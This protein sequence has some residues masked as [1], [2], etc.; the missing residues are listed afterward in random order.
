MLQGALDRSN[1]N[2]TPRQREM[3]LDYCCCMFD[4][5]T[6]MA[7]IP[8]QNTI[9]SALARSIQT[10]PMFAYLGSGR[11]GNFAVV[12]KPILGKDT[13]NPNNYK[14]ALVNATE[15]IPG[16]TNWAAEGTYVQV[17]GG[18][19]IRMDKYINE[20]T[21]GSPGFFGVNIGGTATTT[22]P[23]GASPVLDPLNTGN[24]VHWEVD[25]SGDSPTISAG[26]GVYM[27]TIY[28]AQ[29]TPTFTFVPDSSILFETAEKDD[30]G[31]PTGTTYWINSSTDWSLRIGADA[32]NTNSWMTV[33]PGA[34]NG[35]PPWLNG[36]A[37][38]MIRPV[39]MTML[40]TP[41][42]SAL[43]N[44]GNVAAA[45][46]PANTC[47][48]NWFTTST[49]DSVGQLQNWENIDSL[50]GTNTYSGELQHGAWVRY[51]PSDI[52]DTNYDTPENSL[53]HE[54]P[55]LLIAGQLNTSTALT[56]LIFIGRLR[57]VTVYEFQTNTSLWELHSNPGSTNMFEQALAMLHDQPTA[58]SNGKHLEAIKN[59]LSS[60]GRAAASAGK[61]AYD[62]RATII[63][64]AKTI[65]SLL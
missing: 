4:P 57:V 28:M 63:P 47:R 18:H 53:N 43:N 11:T 44:G 65:A 16:D 26:P 6:Y 9:P 40:F 55:C 33:V 64:V 19:N 45:L 54:F 46:V 13:N 2:V 22:A 51:K 10:I 7:R 3:I 24:V 35:V 50:P 38:S 32:V 27:V 14:I 31:A 5:D 49:D 62:N 34:L 58:F 23:F 21:G 12:A 56:G 1:L 29:A 25:G 42:L 41:S 17:A 20:L 61:F 48:N 30:G 36:G 60:I 59:F 39:A 37:V 52:R 8:D 15:F